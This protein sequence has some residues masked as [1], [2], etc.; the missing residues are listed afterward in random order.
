MMD[1]T[2]KDVVEISRAEVRGVRL[3][4]KIQAI[5]IDSRDVREGSLFV[6]L[7][8]MR[9]HGHHFIPQV[10]SRGGVALAEASF[11]PVLGPTLLVKSPLE[12]MGQLT[13]TLIDS[14]RITVVG[15]TGSVG[16][17][18]LKE[19]T[20]AALASRYKVG[21]SQG[22]YNTAI[23]VPLSFLRSRDNVTHFVSEMGMRALGEI[24]SLTKITPPDVAVITN[25]GPNHLESLG[26]MENIQRAKGE[27]LEGLKVG[28]RAVLNGDDPLVR[29]LGQ[30][31]DGHQVLWFG[32]ESADVVIENVRVKE[33]G[34]E[35]RLRFR[36]QVS[37]LWVPW[38]G[39]QHGY[40]V[41]AAFLVGHLLGLHRDEI[42][43]A[44][45]TVDPDNGRL[46]RRRIGALNVLC[47]YYNAGP[48]SMK[49][50]LEVLKAQETPT[51][52]IAVL[53]D[54]MELG[55]QEHWAHQEV[56]HFAA[57][58][59]EVIRAV[60]PRAKE[61]AQAANTERKGCAAWVQ[62]LDQAK[63]W[64]K[65]NV[66]RDDVLLLK[67]SH[68]MNFDDIYQELARWGGPQ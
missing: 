40:T 38:F 36:D 2:F 63:E 51:R 4:E 6:A 16:K 47:D 56:G 20:W 8:G 1:L 17:T 24:R 42:A 62:D 44:L 49:M 25:I 5:T 30:H 64:I 65:D 15:I 23:G 50:S 55:N 32:Y 43:G 54:M 39:R 35:V 22:N 41:A 48:A 45:E 67:A 10:W 34:T 19:L 66:Q 57:Q 18:S 33:T 9:T 53:G 61:I 21:K 14:K 26:S 59:A 12:T 28:G 7:P 31:L 13:R 3:D 37:T 27:I 68:S 46:Q 52:R 11:G 29:Q 58:M 60:G